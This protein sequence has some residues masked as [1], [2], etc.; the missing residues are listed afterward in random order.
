MWS[1]SNCREL[2]LLQNYYDEKQIGFIEKRAVSK[3][4]HTF[5]LSQRDIYQ[6]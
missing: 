1:R 4:M 6:K 3:Q 5:F 2:N